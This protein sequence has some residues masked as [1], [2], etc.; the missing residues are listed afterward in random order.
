MSPQLI[1]HELRNGT[2]RAFHCC[3]SYFLS[4]VLLPRM[5][6]VTVAIIGPLAAQVPQFSFGLTAGVPF[7]GTAPSGYWHDESKRY[8]IGPLLQASFTEHISIVVNP[9]YK[10]TGYSTGAFNLLRDPEGPIRVVETSSRV[11]GHSLE[12]PVMGKYTFRSADKVWRPFVQS[13]FSFQTAWQ[14]TEG[15]SILS[16]QQLN[17]STSSPFT[18][19]RRTSTDAGAVFGAGV[20]LRRGRLQFS[21][22][23]RYTRWGSTFSPARGRHQGDFLLTIRF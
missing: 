14:K 2:G 11:R 22:E 4:R 21:P 3:M 10:R 1:R 19:E 16:N 12:L 23:M 13:G 5:F 8:T 15:I 18:F 20:T 17:T 9:L 7:A 6:C